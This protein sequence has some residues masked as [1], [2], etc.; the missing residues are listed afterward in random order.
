MLN[1]ISPVVRYRHSND[2][3]ADSDIQ[4]IARQQQLLTSMRAEFTKPEN[5]LKLPGVLAMVH[6]GSQTS[7]TPAQ[8]ICLANFGRQLAAGGMRF[9]TLPV[10]PRGA[11]LQMG[12]TEARELIR[13]L[14]FKG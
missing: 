5:L 10:T 8:A 6:K 13:Q 4:R 9:E 11:A 1:G 14:F 3:H 12:R 7:L 2:G